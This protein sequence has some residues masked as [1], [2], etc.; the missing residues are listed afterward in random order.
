[1]AYTLRNFDTQISWH[2]RQRF[3]SEEII[4]IRSLLPTDLEKVAKAFRG[5]KAC[6][7]AAMLNERVG[8]HCRAVTEIAHCCCR[9]V[10]CAGYGAAHAFIDAFGNTAGRILWGRGYLPSF[11]SVSILVEQADVRERPP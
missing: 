3:V 10:A 9:M 2:E 7:N 11:D 5:E 1:M 6:G 8:R 4:E